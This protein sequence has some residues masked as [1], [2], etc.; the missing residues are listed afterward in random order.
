MH[1]TRRAIAAGCQWLPH[2]QALAIQDDPG[3]PETPVTVVLRSAD[4]AAGDAHE[5]RTQLVVLAT[6]LTDNV[7]IAGAE[8]RGRM[9]RLLGRIGAGGVLP[10]A[11]CDLPA[12]ELVMAVGRGGYCGLV[13]LEDGRIDVAAALDR[14]VLA[15]EKEPGRALARLLAEAGAPASCRLPGPDAF[16][17]ASFRAT[18]P[19]TRRSPLAC[20]PTRRILRIGDTAGYVEP[21]T[22][23]GIGWALASGRILAESVTD[24]GGLAAPAAAAARYVAAHHAQFRRLHARCRFVAHALRRPLLVGAAVTAAHAMPWAARILAPVVVGAPARGVHR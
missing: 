14:A 23:E 15:H 19:L 16:R 5:L 7:R 13:R 6:G 24:R 17:E 11:S 21:F 22:G 3:D 9:D 10:A 20:G 1:L 8:S 12:G 4:P 18:P 2:A